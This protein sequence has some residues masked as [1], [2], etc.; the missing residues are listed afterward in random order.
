MARHGSISDF[1][2]AREDWTSYTER[3]MQY[4]TVNDVVSEDKRQA[5]LLSV[6]GAQTYG[7]KKNLLAPE[8]P[9]ESHLQTL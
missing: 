8:K 1:E 9:T 3:L 6:C 2:S 4:F 5:I 7:L